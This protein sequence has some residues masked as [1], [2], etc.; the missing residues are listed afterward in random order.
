V[1]YLGDID[2][3]SPLKAVPQPARDA[4]KHAGST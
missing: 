4:A 3:F 2:A 1:T